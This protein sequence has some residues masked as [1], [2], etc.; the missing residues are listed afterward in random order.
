V[1]VR[2]IAINRDC[3]TDAHTGKVTI[4]KYQTRQYWSEDVRRVFAEVSQISKSA[5]QRAD[6]A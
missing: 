6:A 2:R 4:N 1:G 5:D 3:C